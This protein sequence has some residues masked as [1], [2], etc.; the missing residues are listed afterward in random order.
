MSKE[1]LIQYLKS[2]FGHVSRAAIIIGVPYQQ[3]IDAIRFERDWKIKEIWE[4]ARKY[5]D[6]G[7]P[8]ELD[9]D[10]RKRI[11]TLWANASDQIK[12]SWSASWVDTLVNG[13]RR[14]RLTP[15]VKR[16]IKQL[17]TKK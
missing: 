10:T 13:K 9:S 11:G 17:E 5:K 7:L 15:K 8:G 14:M 4:R 2:K 6:C 12:E 16:L 1:E 3:I